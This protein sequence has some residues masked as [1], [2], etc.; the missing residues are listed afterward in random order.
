MTP[1]K[2][3]LGTVTGVYGVKAEVQI[4]RKE[5]HTYIYT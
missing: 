2:K 3:I 4:F 1:L 5:F